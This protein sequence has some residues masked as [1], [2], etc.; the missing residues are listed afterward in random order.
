VFAS[1]KNAGVWVGHTEVIVDFYLK[2]QLRIIKKS[3]WGLKHKDGQCLP[4][5]TPTLNK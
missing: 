5:H 3:R 2:K 4:L 1:E